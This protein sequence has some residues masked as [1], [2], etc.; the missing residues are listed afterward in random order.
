MCSA[1]A[2][3]GVVPANKWYIAIY[4]RGRTLGV[5]HVFCDPDIWSDMP[6]SDALRRSILAIPA[7]SRQQAAAAAASEADEVFF[8]LEDSLAPSEKPAARAEL[9]ATIRDHEWGET[10]VSYRINGIDTRWWYE[11]VIEPLSEVGTAIDSLIIPKVQEPSD[12]RTVETLVTSLERNIGLTPGE[13]GLSVQIETARGMNN[14]VEIAEASDRLT[15]MIFGPADYAASIGAT[16]GSDEYP[17]HYWHYPLSRLAHAA[18][19]A[20]LTTIGGPYGTDDTEA[21][22]AACRNEHSLGYDGKV[23]IDDAQVDVAN[24]VFAPTADQAARAEEI[25]DRYQRA[26]PT[27][28]VAIDGN[29]IDKEMYRM[30]KRVLSKAEKAGIR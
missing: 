3:A 23:V 4:N 30:A 28:I 20:G 15:A 25:V 12:L 26:D 7:T 10:T 8:D 22:R 14:A 21:F 16:V 5:R 9:V 18:A 17:G 19:G 11:D 2:T 6:L 1:T 29:V 24:D 13:I 27:E